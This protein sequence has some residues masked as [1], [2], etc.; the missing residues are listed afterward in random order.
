MYKS[1]G[2]VGKYPDLS[3]IFHAVAFGH[4]GLSVPLAGGRTTKV[5]RYTNKKLNFISDLGVLYVQQNPN[6]Q[7]AYASRARQGSRIVW[8]IRQSGGVYLG[9]IENGEAFMKEEFIKR[10]SKS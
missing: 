2:S 10:E 1:I 5:G 6:T 4:E 9:Y 8:V 3:A 7:S